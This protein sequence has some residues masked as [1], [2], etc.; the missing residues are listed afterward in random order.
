MTAHPPEESV[1]AVEPWVLQGHLSQP[2]QPAQPTRGWLSYGQPLARTLDLVQASPNQA[3][4]QWA[5]VSEPPQPQ[6][7]HGVPNSAFGS[8]ATERPHV[9][10]WPGCEKRYIRAGDLE[11]HEWNVHRDPSHYLCHFRRCPR[12]IIG[13]GFGRKDKLVDHLKSRKHDLSHEDATYEAG[14]HNTYRLWKWHVM[15]KQNRRRAEDTY[16][17]QDKEPS[18]DA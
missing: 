9:C 3:V 16:V 4:F 1:P 14:K 12:S 18:Y 2:A 5:T 17:Y 11:R 13:R 6:A 10:L 8:T 7:T 15:R